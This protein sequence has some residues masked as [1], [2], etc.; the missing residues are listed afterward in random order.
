MMADSLTIGVDACGVADT[1][2]GAISSWVNAQVEGR[3]PVFLEVR[4]LSEGTRTL[5]FSRKIAPL[6]PPDRAVLDALIREHSH[7]TVEVEWSGV[8]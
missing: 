3:W 8:A 6:T 1:F 4:S 2:S 7:T 5:R